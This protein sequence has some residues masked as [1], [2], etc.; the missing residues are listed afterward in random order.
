[1]R[2]ETFPVWCVV[3]GARVTVGNEIGY[4][5]LPRDPAYIL[6]PDDDDDDDEDDYGK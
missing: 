4:S 5:F 2:M 6:L 3:E 1:M